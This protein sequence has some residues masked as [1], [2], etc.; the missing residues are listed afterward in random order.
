MAD[1]KS[2]A[3]RSKNMSRIRGKDTKPEMLVRR[4]LYSRGFRYRLHGSRDIGSPDLVFKGIKAVV[5]IHGCFW[6]QHTG[7]KNAAI[8]KDDTDDKWALKLKANVDRDEKNKARALETGFAVATIWECALQPKK[9]QS[10]IRQQSIDRLIGWLNR[11][12]REIS[13]E[14]CIE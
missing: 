8:V 1:I 4:A 7:C 9:K 12:G 2:R 10:I 5:F 11:D 6:H 3:D 13:F 14:I